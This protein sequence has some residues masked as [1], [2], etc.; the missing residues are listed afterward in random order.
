V[1]CRYGLL[2]KQAGRTAEAEALFRE[3]VKDARL[4]N[5]HSAELN[6]EWVEIATREVG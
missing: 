4:G 2:L 6:R 1:K 3:I 5:R